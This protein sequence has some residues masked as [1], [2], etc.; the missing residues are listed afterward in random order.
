ML[1]IIKNKQLFVKSAFTFGLAAADMIEGL[2]LVISSTLKVVRTLN[3]IIN[4]S[5]H[6]VVCLKDNILAW[7]G[8]QLPGI[9]LFMIGI[10]RF[11][12]IHYFNWY[13]NKW[14]NKASW[15]STVAGFT[16]CLC[17]VIL[18]IGLAYNQPANSL[19]SFI[20]SGVLTVGKTYM[21]FTFSVSIFGGL[22]A[23]LLTLV[24]LAEFKTKRI[25]FASNKKNMKN[26]MKRQLRT[27]I[28][29]SVI[30][31]LDLC[32][33]VIPNIITMLVNVFDVNLGNMYSVSSWAFFFTTVRS[34]SNLFIY[35][36][37]NQEFRLVAIR[38]TT[39][40]SVQPDIHLKHGTRTHDA[41][42]VY[43][44]RTSNVCL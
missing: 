34:S 36:L 14:T 41:S 37:V 11:V 3:G 40:V 28:L 16:F 20:C 6:P 35:L 33:V 29:M 12:A 27:T 24:A 1:I 2:G 9:M 13:F 32:M 38:F 30:S 42:S 44:K 4:L 8:I 31:I 17:A 43:M 39:K 18:A 19:I 21:T 23:A 7:M 22:M 15:V 10:E 26:H 5:A 25:Q